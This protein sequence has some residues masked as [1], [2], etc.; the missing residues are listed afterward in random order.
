M[1]LFAGVSS[2]SL[3]R[4]GSLCS[5][6]YGVF[7]RTIAAVVGTALLLCLLHFV[8]F[9]DV[10]LSAEQDSEGSAVERI[11]HRFEDMR[12]LEFVNQERV[13]LLVRSVLNRLL[14]VV[15]LAE[16]L[17][18]LIIDDIEQHS[19]LELLHHLF[20]MRLSRSLE[21]DGDVIHFLAIGNRDEDI[22]VHLSLGLED[23]L[24]LRVGNLRQLVHTTF[25]ALECS[26]RE[27]FAQ[28]IAFAAVE[29]FLIKGQ[30]DSEGL[31]DV[32]LESFVVIGCTG[33]V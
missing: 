17:F 29:L 11:Q 9:L 15:Q 6:L 32:V 28:F 12:R 27:L 18:P 2:G 1:N 5:L 14:E 10:Y 22:L 13:F 33:F 19:F 31:H 30:F 23:V 16:V 4:S 20:A 7:L 25:E 24:D 21:V 3:C 26:L 8:G